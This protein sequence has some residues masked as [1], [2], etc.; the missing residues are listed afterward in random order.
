MTR[1]DGLPRLPRT[2]VAQRGLVWTAWTVAA[3]LLLPFVGGAVYGAVVT[4]S[5]LI[6]CAVPGALP[7]RSRTGDRRDLLAVAVLY[8]VVVALLSLAFRVFTTD[9]VLGMFLAFAATLLVGTVGPVVWTVWVRGRPL[10]DL[11]LGVGSWRRTAGL[12]LLFAGVQGALTLWGYDLPAAVDWVPLLVMALVVGIFESVFFRGFVQGRLEEQLGTGPAVGVAAGLYGAYHVGYGM[13]GAD[14]AFLTGLG[15]VYAV[16]YALTRSVLVLW[17][18]LN[19]LGSFYANLEAGEINLPWASIAGFADVAA[20]MA[21]AGWLA[22]R[23]QRGARRPPRRPQRH[24]LP[25]P[26]R[27]HLPDPGVKT[28]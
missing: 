11:G 16:A 23:H 26:R 19:P 9:N 5:A 27:V 3:L 21:V 2:R 7:P 10:G 28:R 22:V 4:A 18:L 14:L 17:P 12:A 6:V 15:V 20:V 8:V 25:A 13:G 24:L 1:P